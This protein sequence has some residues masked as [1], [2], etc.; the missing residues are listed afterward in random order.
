MSTPQA[1][2]P[3]HGITL[4]MILTRLVTHY[5]WQKLGEK[6]RIDCFISNPTINPLGSPKGGNPLPAHQVSLNLAF[7]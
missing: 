4:E 1:K 3:L 5:G 2:D 7:E 6:I